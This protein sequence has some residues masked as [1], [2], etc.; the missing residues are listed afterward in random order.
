MAGLAIRSA[1]IRC[2]DYVQVA[3]ALGGNYRRLAD[4]CVAVSNRSRHGAVMG[5]DFMLIDKN[6]K[7]LV[8]AVAMQLVSNVP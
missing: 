2:A 5:W 4:L 6:R 7:L 3:S 1:A 8:H